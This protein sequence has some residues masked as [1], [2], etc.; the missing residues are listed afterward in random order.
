MTRINQYIFRFYLTAL[1]Q[2]NT[3]HYTNS[4]ALM[5]VF[6]LKVPEKYFFLKGCCRRSLQ[7]NFL[8]NETIADSD[9]PPNFNPLFNNFISG[10][11]LFYSLIFYPDRQFVLM[12]HRAIQKVRYIFLT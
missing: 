6:P 3:T 10:N 12:I 5:I 7:T 4:L 1:L 9:R 8:S 11:H 2:T